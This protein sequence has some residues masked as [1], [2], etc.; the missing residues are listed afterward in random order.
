MWLDRMSFTHRGLISG[1]ESRHVLPLA[2][3][4]VR[5]STLDRKRTGGGRRNAILFGGYD[6]RAAVRETMCAVIQGPADAGQ[7]SD[8]NGLRADTTP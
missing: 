6:I 5:W 1:C 8:Y 3:S 4:I 2:P 7:W